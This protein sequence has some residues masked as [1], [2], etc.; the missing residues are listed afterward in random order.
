MPTRLV[1]AIATFVVVVAGVVGMA[2]SAHAAAY[3]YWTYWQGGTG[4]WAFATAGPAS[5]VPADGSVEGWRFAVTTT[6]GQASDAP[7]TKPSF[8]DICGSTP[9]QPDRKRV[10]L[11]VDPGP[12]SIA[13]EGQAPPPAIA[14]CI[15]AEPDA[16]GYQVLRAATTVR[17]DGG[18]ICAISDYPTGECAP[19]VEDPVPVA[20]SSASSS[21]A[22]PTTTAMEPAAQAPAESSSGVPWFTVAVVVL[23]AIAGLVLWRRRQRD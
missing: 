15:V 18:L 2:G 14:S 10:A 22:T 4:T 6:A 3:R 13:P 16:T 9:A 23:L 11:V 21:T 8:A 19:V 20:S 17:T 5:L 7:T 12:A 1:S